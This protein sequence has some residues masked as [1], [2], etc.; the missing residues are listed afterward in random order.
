M[1]AGKRVLA[2]GGGERTYTNTSRIFCKGWATAKVG[3][4]V[5]LGCLRFCQMRAEDLQRDLCI[6]THQESREAKF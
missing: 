5:V 2:W 3:T 1:E 4:G 6:R